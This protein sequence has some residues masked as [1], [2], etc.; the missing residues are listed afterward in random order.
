M[1]ASFIS[2]S[3]AC[4]N[5][6]GLYL[7]LRATPTCS[8]RAR[9]RVVPGAVSGSSSGRAGI[10]DNHLG[11]RAQIGNVHTSGGAGRPVAHVDRAVLEA[12]PPDGDAQ[13]D[14]D[15]VGVREL[16]PARA[17]ARSSSRTSR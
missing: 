9:P 10:A 7:R 4:P 12:L 13:R 6:S 17:S 11:L 3:T 5:G 16:L 2:R 15:Q 1:P 8:A 14:P